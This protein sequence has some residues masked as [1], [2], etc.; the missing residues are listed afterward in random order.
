MRSVSFIR[1]MG[2]QQT[3]NQKH[4]GCYISSSDQLLR[5]FQSRKM[6]IRNGVSLVKVM[7]NQL[8]ARKEFPVVRWMTSRFMDRLRY[9]RDTPLLQEQSPGI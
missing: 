1:I 6:S 9:F 2:S 4:R 3:C 8:G 7:T 5:L